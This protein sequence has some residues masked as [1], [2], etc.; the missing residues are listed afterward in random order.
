MVMLTK[1]EGVLI[2]KHT[3]SAINT[4]SGFIVLLPSYLIVFPSSSLTAHPSS[5][6]ARRVQT[7]APFPA[8]A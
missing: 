6:P 7:V 3:H 2:E 1:P 8:L 5:R 4:P